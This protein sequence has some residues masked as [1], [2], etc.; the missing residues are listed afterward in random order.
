M[1]EQDSVKK[2][3]KMQ[4]RPNLD[5]ALLL[6]HSSFTSLSTQLEKKGRKVRKKERKKENSSPDF[7]LIQTPTAA[8]AEAVKLS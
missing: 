1:S 5:L 4:L 2:F 6:V 7:H 3:V 8:A